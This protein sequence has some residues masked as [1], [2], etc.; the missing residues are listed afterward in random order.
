[1]A[2]PKARPARTVKRRRVS[3]DRTIHAPWPVAWFDPRG[4]IELNNRRMQALAEALE[5]SKKAGINVFAIH[6]NAC[7]VVRANDGDEDC[8]CIPLLMYMG[9][10]A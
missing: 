7:T 1:M 5:W 9:H 2:K 8:T 3:E 10:T 6:R 4:I